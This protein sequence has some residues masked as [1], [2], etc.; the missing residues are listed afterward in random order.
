MRVFT[1][2]CGMALIVAGC[3][4]DEPAQTASGDRDAALDRDGATDEDLDASAPDASLDAS[5][6]DDAGDASA[7][8]D[9][10]GPPAGA[11]ISFG[12]D[13]AHTRTN[14]TEQRISRTSIG[15]LRLAW[16]QDAPGVSATPAIVDGVV[17]WADW[18]GTVYANSVRDGEPL[19]SQTFPV[20]FT[21]SP[22]VSGDR[23]FVA[24]RH[25]T[26]YALARDDG[27]TIWSTVVDEVELTHLWSSPIVVDGI[28]IIGTS[29]DGT[30]ANRVPLPQ[31][32]IATFRGAVLGLSAENGEVLWRFE[33]TRV[34]GE[35]DMYGPGVSVW[36]T[37]SVDTE[38]EA[39]FI[40][41]GNGYATP[42]S[43]YSDAL[44]AIFYKTGELA[45]STQFTAEDAF[46]SGN[47]AGGPDSDVGG[48]PNLFTID[49]DGIARDVVGVGDKAGTYRVLDRDSGEVIWERVLS[50]VP[51]AQK[52]GGII[53]PAAY[54]DGRIFVASNV[55]Y[56][57]SSVF[58]LDAQTGDVAWQSRVLNSVNF[59]GPAIANG[60]L[61]FG[62]SGLSIIAGASD[63]GLGVGAPGKL[64]AFDTDTG[65][66]L[67][68]T[69]LKAGRGAGFAISE[70]RVFI[71]SGFTFY[72]YADEPLTGALQVFDVP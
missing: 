35:P 44:L 3:S 4:D 69:E 57:S 70:G 43:P 71:G 25:N 72:A 60:V 26:V 46:S 12:G 59:G 1:W 65:E 2:V 18:G 16:E 48:A 27:E 61:L 52:T 6:A 9:A 49:A 58:A 10:G 45:W 11:W 29:S 34:K 5:A 42:V 13:Y 19:W 22:F 21:S 47:S 53:A 31:E 17:Y 7:A 14:P 38:R 32:T 15:E 36:A 67:F 63:A 41:T 62:D 40:G 55:S 50:T 68:E 37:A 33:T 66:E 30:Q 28:V 8:D 56:V 24:D 54:A 51:F 39:L 64:I 20:G 23:V